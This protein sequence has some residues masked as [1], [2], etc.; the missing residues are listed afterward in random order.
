MAMLQPIVERGNGVA[1]KRLSRKL[2]MEKQSAAV[3]HIFEEFM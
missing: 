2:G 3:I 1:Q